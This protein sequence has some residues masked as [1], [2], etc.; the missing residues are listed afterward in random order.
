MVVDDAMQTDF[1]G[2]L[3][4]EK[5]D[6]TD[7]DFADN[8]DWVKAEIKKELFTSQFGQTLGNQVITLWDPQIQKALTYMPEAQALENHTLPSQQK[9]QT[10]AVKQ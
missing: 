5:V 3:K 6:Y 1:K 8:I 2:F 7:K 10:A 4:T 9:T